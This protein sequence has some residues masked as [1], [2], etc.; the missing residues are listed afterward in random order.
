MK[1]IFG[2][3]EPD[4]FAGKKNICGILKG[5]MSVIVGDKIHNRF[6]ILWVKISDCVILGNLSETRENWFYRFW[7]Y[8]K[9]SESFLDETQRLQF[10]KFV[11]RNYEKHGPVDFW[12]VFV[13]PSSR[14]HLFRNIGSD[15]L[16]LLRIE[17]NILSEK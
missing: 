16:R 9:E 14:L 15:T 8:D 1:S 4:G 2:V 3:H 11:V 13:F 7:R 10:L 6:T 17:H 5:N 12:N